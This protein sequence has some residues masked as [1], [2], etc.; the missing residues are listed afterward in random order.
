[1]RPTNPV[2]P[3]DL[4]KGTAKLTDRMG[5]V[6]DTMQPMDCCACG[7]A[8]YNLTF[9][10]IW[11]PQTHPKD[12]PHDNPGLLHWTNLIGA[13]HSPHF[14]IFKIGEPAN[15]AVQS[16][17][18]YGD[19]TVMKQ[20]LS[21]AATIKGMSSVQVG[22][23]RGSTGIS[24]LF[25]L[26]TAPGMWHADTLME[27]RTTQI[28]VNRTHPLFSLI[29][30]LGPSPDWCT[31]LSG[32]S[33]CRSDCTWADNLEFFLYPFDAGFREG[34]TYIPKNSDRLA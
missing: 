20:T 32:Q 5:S 29:T 21:M 22:S 34:N 1:M 13:T 25:S 17:C 10:G 26:L 6:K 27:S 4:G 12:W 14:H 19:I 28:A 24:P 31:G 3:I 23:Q 18:A 7:T 9:Q 2:L 15:S 16:V 33:L 11:S 30:M 8:S